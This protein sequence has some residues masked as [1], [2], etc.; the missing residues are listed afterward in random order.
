MSASET[1]GDEPAWDEELGAD[2]ALEGEVLAGRYRIVRRIGQGGMATVYLAE[3]VDIGRRCAVKVLSPAYAGDPEAVERFLREARAASKIRHPN[4]I[5]ITDFGRA[6]GTV[7]FVMELLE[8]EDLLARIERAGRLA[9]PEAREAFLQLADALAAA[10]ARGIVHRDLKPEN[11]F[12]VPRAGGGVTIK[13]LDFGIAKVNTSTLQGPAL[14]QMGRVFGTPAYMSPEQAD[15]KPADLRTDVYSLGVTMYQALTGRLP[16]EA[17]TV[18]GYLKQHMFSAPRSLRAVAPEAA[19]APEV[20]AIVLKA[21]Q[22]DP[23]LRFQGMEAVAAAILAVG[24]GKAPV[25]VVAEALEEPPSFAG[26]AMGFQP[27]EGT[28][29]GRRGLVVLGGAVAVVALAGAWWAIG[30]GSPPDA[31]PAAQEPVVQAAAPEVVAPTP[32][33]ARTTVVLTIRSNVA[34]RVVDRGAPLGSTGDAGGIV[35]PF[36]VEAR[37]LVLSAEGYEDEVVRVVPD[38]DQEVN[39]VL[40]RSGAA[41]SKKKRGGKAGEKGGSGPSLEPINPFKKSPR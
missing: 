40:R 34:A 6:G 21:L 10:H 23:A 7:F 31:P 33:P 32:A 27:E 2:P 17:D 15:G 22:K 4:I 36:G 8:G 13:V 35:L 24:T 18:M 41:A 39:V 28:R 25:K 12:C 1:Q 19:I 29:G 11:C 20:E 5:E 16:F 9:W 3:H 14:T 38:R 26:R 30:R 37:E